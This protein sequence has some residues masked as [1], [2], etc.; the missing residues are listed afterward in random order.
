MHAREACV[1]GSFV[2]NN[3][4]G[5]LNERAPRAICKRK[6]TSNK[7]KHCIHVA[8]NLGHSHVAALDGN[9]DI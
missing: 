2:P 8:N 3:T 6:N 4:E 5:E 7:T 9:H 1:N